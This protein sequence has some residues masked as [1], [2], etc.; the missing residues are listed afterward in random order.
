MQRPCRFQHKK[1]RPFQQNQ[2]IWFFKRFLQLL[3][4]VW[5]PVSVIWYLQHNKYIYLTAPAVAKLSGCNLFLLYSDFQSAFVHTS[6]DVRLDPVVFWDTSFSPWSA[7]NKGPDQSVY[8]AG[9]PNLNII[10]HA[11]WPYAVADLLICPLYLT[12]PFSAA[13]STTDLILHAT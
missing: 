3:L 9:A 6:R 12:T 2:F 5:C 7:I 10:R 1:T 8:F 11:C 4:P 13:Y